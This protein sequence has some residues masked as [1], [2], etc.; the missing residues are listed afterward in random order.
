MMRQLDGGGI[1]GP[2]AP[3]GAGFAEWLIGQG[4]AMSSVSHQLGLAGWLSRWLAEENLAPDALSEVVVHRFVLA[5]SQIGLGRPCAGPRPLLTYLRGLGV[6]PSP[7][8]ERDESPQ[9]CLLLAYERYLTGERSLRPTTVTKYLH[10]ATVFLAAVPDPLAEALSGLS[11]DQVT[12]FVCG[13][14][15]GAKSIAGGL[16]VFLR[17]LYLSGRVE[18]Q[19]AEAVPPAAGW[20]LSGLPARLDAAVVA[21]AMATCDRPNEAGCRDYAILLLLARL[22]LR[23]HEVAGLELEDIRWRAGTLVLR[24][25]GGRSEEL[26]LPV[27]VGQAMAD[28]LLIRPAGGAFRAVFMSVVAP[29]RPVTRSSMT[30][31]ARR[32]CAA[33]GVASGGAHRLRH[34]L[35]SDLLAAGASLAEIGLVLGHRSPFVTSI[36]A[37]VDR[38]ALTQLVRPWPLT[39]TQQS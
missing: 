32:H 29:R 5:R 22:G 11:A 7:E 27:D 39:Q 3:Y 21:A 14:G 2:L 6:M 30:L 38:V 15:A 4:Y 1:D 10:I 28:Y 31:M 34:T 26:P 24:R 8:L 20:K 9:R 33:V 23:A 19:L 18:R 16:R 12:G 25:K 37:K 17:Y 36:Y 35:A 13:K